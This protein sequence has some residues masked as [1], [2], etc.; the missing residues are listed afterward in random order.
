MSVGSEKVPLSNRGG[1]PRDPRIEQAVLKATAELLVRRGYQDLNLDEIAQRAKTTKPAIYRRW[2]S[3]ARLVHEAAFPIEAV[4]VGRDPDA[5]GATLAEDIR[6]MVE[7]TAQVLASPAARAALP[8][9]IPEFQA[10]PE[11]HTLLLQRFQAGPITWAVE[12]IDTAIREGEARAGLDA[13]T[14]LAGIAGAV[15]FGLFVDANAPLDQA[16]VDRTTD[17]VLNGVLP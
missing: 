2:K 16:W 7:N 14:V 3:K 5:K 10:D 4:A 6:A 8:G 13:L 12:R 9:L 17:L 15:F 1:R 11:L